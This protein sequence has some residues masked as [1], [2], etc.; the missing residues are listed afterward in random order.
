MISVDQVWEL[1]CIADLI[2]AMAPLHL[3]AHADAVEGNPPSLALGRQLLLRIRPRRL[4]RCCWQGRCFCIRFRPK[5]GS[6]HVALV[7][8]YFVCLKLRR[9]RSLW[10]RWQ[11]VTIDSKWGWESRGHRHRLFAGLTAMQRGLPRNWTRTRTMS[12]RGCRQRM[13]P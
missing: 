11:A 12:D 9:W 8:A 1:C 4:R 13:P 7:A 10:V 3:H 6:L 5:P 2:N